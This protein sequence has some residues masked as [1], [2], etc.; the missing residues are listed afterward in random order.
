MLMLKS[1]MRLAKIYSFHR[2][3]Y[4][5]VL[6]I[7]N[8]CTFDDS[9]VQLV[10]INMQNKLMEIILLLTLLFKDNYFIHR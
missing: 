3:K 2:K 8:V 5:V 6:Q 4:I 1:D 9:L 7:S 10:F